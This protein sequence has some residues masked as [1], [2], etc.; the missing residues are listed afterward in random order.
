MAEEFESK[1]CLRTGESKTISFDNLPRGTKSEGKFR[2]N[3]GTEVGFYVKGATGPMLV[4]QKSSRRNFLFEVVEDH[5]STLF[6]NAYS[7]ITPKIV[8]LS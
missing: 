8:D 4:Y 6:D 5:A 2:L 1:L 3:S 7:A